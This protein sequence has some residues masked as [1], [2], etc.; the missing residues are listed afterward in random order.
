[1]KL[2]AWTAVWA[3]VAVLAACGA[4]DGPLEEAAEDLDTRIENTA[5]VAADLEREKQQIDISA[6]TA[7]AAD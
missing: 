2:R 1:M 7:L 5:D 3:G 4:S 6:D